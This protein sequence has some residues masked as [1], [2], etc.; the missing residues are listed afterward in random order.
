MCVHVCARVSP[1]ERECLEA[2][3]HIREH[4]EAV[5]IVDC[6]KCFSSLSV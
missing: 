5:R 4:W 3:Q 6:A 1:C 2:G